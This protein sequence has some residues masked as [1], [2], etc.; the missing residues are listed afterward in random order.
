MKKK[1]GLTTFGLIILY[2]FLT[3]TSV[4]R[5]Y[6]ILNE[7]IKDNDFRPGNVC[8]HFDD[9]AFFDKNLVD[10][11]IWDK[12]SAQTQKLTNRF[13]TMRENAIQYF[14]GGTGKLPVVSRLELD[15]DIDHKSVYR[16]SLPIVSTDEETVLLKITEGCNCNLGGQG[17]EYSFKRTDGKWRIT[18]RFNIWIS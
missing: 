9:V 8:Y 15:C 17:A 7:I 6:E 5:K 16:I 14:P 13:Y 10:F 18:N 12:L 3:F 1:I 2:Y 11:G 4:D